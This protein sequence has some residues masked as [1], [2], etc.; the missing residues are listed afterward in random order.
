MRLLRS[1]RRRAPA[2]STCS[3]AH[4]EARRLLVRVGLATAWTDDFHMA[5]A[6]RDMMLW[7]K[8]YTE[9]F[10]APLIH[11]YAPAVEKVSR[12]SSSSCLLTVMSRAAARAPVSLDELHVSLGR[13]GTPSSL[14]E[15]HVSLRGAGAPSSLGEA[16][17]SL[18]GYADA[19][20]GPSVFRRARTRPP[21]GLP[22]SFGTARSSPVALPQ[23]GDRPHART[24]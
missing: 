20:L 7:A 2:G 10:V 15:A 4:A 23:S 17:V 18:A 5:Q 19:L 9:R 24:A 3:G 14:S 22:S 16:H 11:Q 8:S 21:A 12:A 13:A 1:K 6:S